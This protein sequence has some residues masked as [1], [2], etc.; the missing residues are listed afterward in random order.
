M[1]VEE[2]FRA[3]SWRVLNGVLI[4]GGQQEGM[5][6][7]E[8]VTKPDFKQLTLPAIRLKPKEIKLYILY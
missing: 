5:W 4:S 1:K 2:S 8:C 6:A 7:A 3:G